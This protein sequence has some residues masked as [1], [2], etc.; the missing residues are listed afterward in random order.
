MSAE[1]LRKIAQAHKKPAVAVSLAEL[2]RQLPE[3]VEDILAALDA[4]V[5]PDSVP[6]APRSAPDAQRPGVVKAGK[7]R[8]KTFQEVYDTDRGYCAWAAGAAE[9][10]GPLD[11]FAKWLRALNPVFAK[12]AENIY[13]RVPYAR[14]DQAK[15]LGAR[16]DPAK[17]MWYAPGECFEELLGA[18]PRVD[19]P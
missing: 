11:D 13:L 17:K 12:T 7:H 9:P 19:R 5:I 15:Q 8:G 3:E 10:D 6:A 2:E 14:R 16:W 1:A 4:S 18:F